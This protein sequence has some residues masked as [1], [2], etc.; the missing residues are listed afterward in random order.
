MQLNNALVTL[1]GQS[2]S[3]GPLEQSKYPIAGDEPDYDN[4]QDGPCYDPPLV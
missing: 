2:P 1:V 3:L 4:L